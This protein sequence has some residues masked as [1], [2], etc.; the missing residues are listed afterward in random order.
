[1]NNLKLG[2]CCISKKLTQNK[3]FGFQTMTRKRFLN[4][5]RE[6]AIEILSKKILNNVNVTLQTIQHCYDNNIF[7]YR[8]SSSL[9]PLISDSISNVN[10]ND[11]PDVDDIMDVIEEIGE[12]IRIYGMTVSSHPDQYVVLANDKENVINNSIKDLEL[13]A[14][15]HD[16]LGLPQDYSNPINIHPTGTPK[17]NFNAYQIVDLFMSNFNKLSSSV[18]N[19]LVLENVDMGYWNCENLYYYFHDYCSQQYNHEFPLTYDN[20]HDDINKSELNYFD[21]FKSSWKNFVPVMHLSYGG[22]NNKKRAHVDSINFFP[23]ILKENQDLIWE[24]ELKDKDVAIMD[25]FDMVKI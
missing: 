11:L 20:L 23:L 2:L 19:R 13:H 5:P 16:S 1:M 6:E 25:I 21:K 9:F 14:W 3:K 7:H 22:K 24:V 15:M 8:L 18:Q 10:I 17:P 12:F 4:L